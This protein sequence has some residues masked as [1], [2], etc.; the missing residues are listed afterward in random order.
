MSHYLW[1]PLV[2]AGFSTGVAVE[3]LAH[4]HVFAAALNFVAVGCNLAAYRFVV[5]SRHSENSK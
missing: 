1:L 4:G 5:K 2:C 3:E